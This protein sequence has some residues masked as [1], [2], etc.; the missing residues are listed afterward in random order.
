MDI[1]VISL[2][3][4]TIMT[5]KRDFNLFILMQSLLSLKGHSLMFHLC[6]QVDTHR[7]QRV[8]HQLAQAQVS[9]Q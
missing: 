3:T 2:E 9:Q 8:I 7:T 6:L 5:T 1:L 4:T